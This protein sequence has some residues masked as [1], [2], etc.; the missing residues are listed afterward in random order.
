MYHHI[1]AAQLIEL[2]RADRQLAA[3]RARLARLAG[4]DRGSR[5][6]RSRSAS[7]VRQVTPCSA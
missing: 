7:A 4:V 6:D 5:K 1:H 2:L 3:D